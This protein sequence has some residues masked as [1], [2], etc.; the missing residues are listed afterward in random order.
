MLYSSMFFNVFSV[1]GFYICNIAV[2]NIEIYFY[3]IFTFYTT[4][5]Y[6]NNKNVWILFAGHYRHVRYIFDFVKWI[7]IYLNSTLKFEKYKYIYMNK[8]FVWPIEY[9]LKCKLSYFMFMFK[10][11]IKCVFNYIKTYFTISF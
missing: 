11:N 6:Q 7:S 3:T 9:V 4:D 10:K 2:K 8:W 1:L 5:W